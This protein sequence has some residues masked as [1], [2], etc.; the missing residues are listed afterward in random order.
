MADTKQKFE[1]VV[2]PAG[3]AVYPRLTT[4]DTKF[5]PAGVYKI[6][7]RLPVAEAQPLI[8]KIDAIIEAKMEEEK[9]TLAA[10]GKAG[11]AKALKFADDRPYKIEEDDNGNP[12]GT[13]VFNFK[14]KAKIEL[15][16]GSTKTQRPTVVDA[17]KNRVTEDVW[18]G[19]TVKVGGSIVPFSTKIGVGAGLRL[20]AVQVLNL[21]QG[22]DASSM[23]SEEDGYEAV[24]TTKPSEPAVA[25][26]ETDDD[27]L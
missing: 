1:K 23:F 27:D 5:N 8:D 26:A 13:V 3:T 16:D 2:T 25:D 10:A 11:K 12:L 19:S 22:G 7:V 14:M 15:K 17:K 4:P 21:V 9:A 18:G 20:L 24:E 6:G